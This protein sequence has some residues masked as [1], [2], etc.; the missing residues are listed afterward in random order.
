[1]QL[2]SADSH[3]NE[4]PQAWERIPEEFRERGPRIVRNPAGAKGLYLVI[5]GMK[6]EAVGVTFLAGKNRDTG[7]FRQTIENFEWDDWKGPWD[8][9]ER[10]KD[11][12]LDGVQA[13]VLYP[14]MGRNLYALKDTPLQNACLRSYNDWLHD[15]CAESP[16]RLFGLAMLSA[17]DVEW[18]V[19]ELERCAKL[20]FKGCI[21]PSALP[22]QQSYASDDFDRLWESAQEIGLPICF[23]ENTPQGLERAA[24]VQ[25]GQL[26][27][28]QRGRSR[29]R[30]WIEPQIVLVDLIFGRVLDRFPHLQFVFA[31]Y[32]LCWIGIILKTDRAVSRSR[33]LGL[34]DQTPINLPSELLKRQ[35]H[36]TFMQDRIGI[37]GT[38]VFG[39]DNYMWSSDYPHGGS[40]WPKSQET[41]DTVLRGLSKEAQRKLTWENGA[42]LYG[43]S[44]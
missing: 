8:P 34:L 15:Y 10:L 21:L 42:R 39:L 23:H 1:M 33:S 20:G 13:E 19:Q 44:E 5:D 40:C 25:S 16:K 29:I 7:N 18:S 37:L 30:A 43:V 27:S 9:R 3:V 22:E 38:E 24:V 6:P 26:S 41:V 2:F 35:I 31:E 4:P 36:F 17:L 12:E 11:M 32:E 14:S 28:I